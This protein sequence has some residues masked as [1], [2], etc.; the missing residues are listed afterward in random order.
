MSD[1][2]L[3]PA[4]K[5]LASPLLSAST[6]TSPEPGGMAGMLQ[7][8]LKDPLQAKV[9]PG[10]G[11]SSEQQ[12]EPG[13]ADAAM[14]GP[15]IASGDKVLR[16]FFLDA[17]GHVPWGQVEHLLGIEEP[18]SKGVRDAFHA[19]IAAASL[20]QPF[21]E[22]VL[23]G[24]DLTIQVEDHE[25]LVA[26]PM[27]IVPG[28]AGDETSVNAD[29]LASGQDEARRMVREASTTRKAVDREVEGLQSDVQHTEGN[30]AGKRKGSAHDPEGAQ[31]KLKSTERRV[32]D[33]QRTVG[34]LKG[35]ATELRDKL[36]G[37]GARAADRVD[38]QIGLAERRLA[39]AVKLLERMRTASLA[40]GADVQPEKQHQEAQ[41]DTQPAPEPV[42]VQEVVT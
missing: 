42:E 25:I 33:L 34:E 1:V 41:P 27:T 15:K 39:E 9:P 26:G 19:Q 10:L 2:M 32:G 30:S 21:V 13:K 40:L 5:R 38:E 31:D 11:G 17:V 12:A 3:M 14:G 7:D 35:R 16:T 8:A 29:A 18:I 23:K 22:V 20:D 24:G 37:K 6:T 4:I 36:G 28:Y